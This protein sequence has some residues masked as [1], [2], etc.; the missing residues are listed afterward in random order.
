ML[1]AKAVERNG[2]ACEWRKGGTRRR[3]ASL[4]LWVDFSWGEAGRLGAYVE[5]PVSVG[6][7]QDRWRLHS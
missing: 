6:L 2:T 4:G 5:P 7:R 3:N 1:A